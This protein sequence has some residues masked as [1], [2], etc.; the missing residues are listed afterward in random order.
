[1]AEV[2]IK[3]I[4]KGNVDLLDHKYDRK[5]SKEQLKFWYEKL[6]ETHPQMEETFI[7][8]ILDYYSTHPHIFDQLVEEHKEN[9]EKFKKD[10]TFDPE[11]LVYPEE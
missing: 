9:P 1:M 6:K 11:T 10:E 4:A 3:S 2:D 8:Q 7:I 5:F